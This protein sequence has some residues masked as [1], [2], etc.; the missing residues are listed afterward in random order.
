MLKRSSAVL[1]A[2][3]LAAAAPAL[4]AVLEPLTPPAGL[5]EG[6]WE[7][8]P[9]AGFTESYDDNIFFRPGT[10]S[11]G[12]RVGSWISTPGAGLKLS[13]APSFR[14]RLDLSYDA[15]DRLY[16]RDPDV[17][18]AFI[19]SAGLR[20]WYQSAAGLVARLRDDYLNTVD[21]AS[22]E[23]TARRRRWINVAGADLGWRPEG[24]RLTASV[25]AQQTRHKYVVGEPDLA[26]LLDRY[27]QLFGARVG[28]RLQPKTTLYAQYH[29]QLIHFTDS[30]S[31]SRDSK[32]HLV[33]FGVEGELTP[34]VSGHAQVGVAER[35][36]DAAP[37]PGLDAD[38]RN[39]T[40][41]VDLAWRPRETSEA[42]LLLS[43]SLEES[44]FDI[45]Q[46]YIASAAE[47]RLVHRFPWRLT[48][49]LDGRVE[50]GTYPT[51]TLIAGRELVRR[52]DDYRAGADLEYPVGGR[53]TAA[54]GYHY[55]ARFSK[56]LSDQFGFRDQITSLSLTASF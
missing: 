37:G 26:A 17:N 51:T 34:R 36:Y 6:A 4:G 1:A 10:A 24:R 5:T 20:Y 38:T 31:P 30:P 50:R 16:S 21:P 52:D 45:N 33:D 14:H 18:N 46:V 32:G 40:A 2:A 49:R 9:S 25:G 53:F 44:A 11:G 28:W 29:R 56:G 54:A 12:E 3:C 35:R 41:S 15:A 42:E 13:A 8:H 47:L 23:L 43:R 48:A 27:D 7:V 22:S 55:R 19:Q 39:L